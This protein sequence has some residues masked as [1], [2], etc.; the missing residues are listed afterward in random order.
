MNEHPILFSGPMV[1]A[2]L[3]GRKTQTRR[4]VRPQPA[5]QPRHAASFYQLHGGVQLY[6]DGNKI[7]SCPYG[8]PGDRLWVRETWKY[9]D[10]AHSARQYPGWVLIGFRADGREKSFDHDPPEK[11]KKDPTWKG[12]E[13][14][15]PWR[16]SI[17]MPRGASRITLEVVS[18]RVERVQ[19]ISRSDALAEGFTPGLNG[20]ESWD[21][22]LYGNSQ[23]AFEAC[24]ESINA[25]RGYGWDVNPWV[26][27]VEFK[28][29]E[30]ASLL[31]KP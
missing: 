24:W 9:I 25:K 6:D 3:D 31:E 17:H 10:G 29:L 19:E 1:R 22:K 27:V 28:R 16:P 20:L 21:G 14:I 13:N 30:N 26:W 5:D 8:D 11:W 23:L 12:H 18:V 4:V 7:F 2:I 15:A